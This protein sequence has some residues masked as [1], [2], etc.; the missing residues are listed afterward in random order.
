M[1]PE[2][3][4]RIAAL[5]GAALE[6]PSSSR[7]EFLRANCREDEILRLEVE[8]L[9]CNGAKPGLLDS[10]DEFLRRELKSFLSIALKPR[11]LDSITSCTGFHR[12][13][14]AAGG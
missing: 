4:E 6:L 12:H 14:R 8:S 11:L 1:T 3:W 13:H 5:Y 9:L 7:D 2:Q 10:R